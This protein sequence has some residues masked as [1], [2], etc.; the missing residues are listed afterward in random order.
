MRLRSRVE[1]PCRSSS[2]LYSPPPYARGDP[3]QV[4]HVPPG[5]APLTEVGGPGLHPDPRRHPLGFEK[6]LAAPL[7]VGTRGILEKEVTV[8]LQPGTL[9]LPLSTPPPGSLLS[10]DAALQVGLGVLR[11]PWCPPWTML[12]CVSLSPPWARG[13]GTEWHSVLVRRKP[14][15]GKERPRATVLGKVG[16][17]PEGGKDHCGEDAVTVASVP[18]RVPG[19][20]GRIWFR[21]LH[22]HWPRLCAFHTLAPGP[23][24]E[25]RPVPQIRRKTL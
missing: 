24:S 7:N 21:F 16:R 15:F 3:G 25:L 4:S 19:F 14:P 20:V 9:T 12:D 17:P 6:V 5:A 1:C 13:P 10:P 18:S 8:T 2:A 11:S 23:S 22:E